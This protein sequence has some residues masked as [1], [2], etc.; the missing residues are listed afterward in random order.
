MEKR[1]YWC[2][3]GNENICV[4]PICNKPVYDGAI[5]VERW[6]AEC[7]E[8]HQITMQRWIPCKERLPEEGKIIIVTYLSYDG[9]CVATAEIDNNTKTFKTHRLVALTFLPN[10][11]DLREVNHIDGNKK[12]NHIENLE[13]VS[14]KENVNHAFKIGLHSKAKSVRVIETGEIFNSVE[15]FKRE[16]GI[17]SSSFTKIALLQGKIIKGV[18]IEYV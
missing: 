12:N 3:S 14:T 10:P 18:H 6:H 1:N 9:I 17:K 8:K 15:E 16:Y 13:W 4:C 2:Y 11:L 5:I 7:F